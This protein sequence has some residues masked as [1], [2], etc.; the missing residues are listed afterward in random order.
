MFPTAPS[1]DASSTSATIAALTV[2]DIIQV[3]AADQS[4][5]A[6]LFQFPPQRPDGQVLPASPI[7]AN[8]AIQS[9]LETTRSRV[10]GFI[11]LLLICAV[12]P[13][14]IART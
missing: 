8:R 2:A 7:R 3:G 5:L 6:A 12:V 9:T 10:E 14:A 13:P 1:G 4:S 11:E